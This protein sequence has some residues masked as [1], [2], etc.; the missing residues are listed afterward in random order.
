MPSCANSTG[1]VPF[2]G[3]S[4]S[5][6]HR[7]PIRSDVHHSASRTFRTNQPS[8]TGASPE[9]RS[10]SRASGTAPVYSGRSPTRRGLPTREPRP[11]LSSGARRGA[12]IA[13][14][15]ALEHLDGLRA[16]QVRLDIASPAGAH[17]PLAV[18]IGGQLGD[19][20]RPPLRN[21]PRA[22]PALPSAGVGGRGP[23]RA[24]R[25]PPGGGG[26]ARQQ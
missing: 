18:R 20:G 16:R 24:G 2:G 14:E 5:K 12:R 1:G 25:G 13:G 17:R 23:P 21:L 15:R 3:Y 6:A 4:H 22:G 11:F 26:P 8:V 19:P 9:P 7:A 10:S